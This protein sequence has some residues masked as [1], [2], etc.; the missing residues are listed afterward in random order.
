MVRDLPPTPLQLAQCCPRARVLHLYASSPKLASGLRHAGAADNT[1]TRQNKLRVSWNSTFRA[2]AHEQAQTYLRMDE[3]Q[4]IQI[5]KYVFKPMKGV[6]REQRH[7]KPVML[8]KG[9]VGVV[10]RTA[11]IVPFSGI[12][13]RRFFRLLH[14]P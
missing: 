5:V 1:K 6:E 13:G 14:L 9:D 10:T 11:E 4:D 7:R 12:L 8:R 2:T 3:I